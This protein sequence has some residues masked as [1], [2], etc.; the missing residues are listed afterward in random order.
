MTINNDPKIAI[1]N[2]TNE[3]NLLM[4]YILAFRIKYAGRLKCFKD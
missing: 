3:K 1:P 2:I 4:Q